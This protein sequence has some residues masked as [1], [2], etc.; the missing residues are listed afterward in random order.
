MERHQPSERYLIFQ[1]TITFLDEWLFY[2]LMLYLFVNNYWNILLPVAGLGT[3]FLLNSYKR[4]WD[5]E[6][7]RFG[8][9]SDQDESDQRVD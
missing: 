5:L 3:A 2:G 4:Q 7:A 6:K 1:R 9:R 8:P